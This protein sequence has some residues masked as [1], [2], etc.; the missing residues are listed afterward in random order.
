MKLKPQKTTIVFLVMITVLLVFGN[1]ASAQQI[2]Q[3]EADGPISDGDIVIRGSGFGNNQGRIEILIDIPKHLRKQVTHEPEI[4]EWGSNTIRCNIFKAPI[5]SFAIFTKPVKVKVFGSSG[6]ELDNKFYPFDDVEPQDWFSS[7]VVSIW[8]EGIVGGR[9]TGIFAPDDQTT[10]AEFIK[11]AVLGAG[12]DRFSFS[13]VPAYSDVTSE[14]WFFPYVKVAWNLGWLDRQQSLFE[15]HR[16]ILRAEAAK[17]IS[18]AVGVNAGPYSSPYHDVSEGDWFALFVMQITEKGIVNGYPDGYFRP[19]NELNR[20][21]ASKIIYL[22]FLKH[23]DEL[24]LSCYGGKVIF[25]V[26]GL[27]SNG[28]SWGLEGYDES[29]KQWDIEDDSMLKALT[30]A[31][32]FYGGNLTKHFDIFNDESLYVEE[33]LD[34][35]TVFSVHFSDSDDLTLVEQANELG[36]IINKVVA[37]RYHTDEII[38]IGHSMGG[39]AIRAYIE[40]SS[41][42]AQGPVAFDPV[43]TPENIRNRSLV[44]QVITVNTPHQGSPLPRVAEAYQAGEVDLSAFLFFNDKILFAV[45]I[46]VGFMSGKEAIQLLGDTNTQDLNTEIGRLQET[47]NGA[48]YNRVDS[49]AVA[50]TKDLDQ[51]IT[52][53]TTVILDLYFPGGY[54]AAFETMRDEVYF[55]FFYNRDAEYPELPDCQESDLVV[56]ASSQLA[57]GKNNPPVIEGQAHNGSIHNEAVKSLVRNQVGEAGYFLCPR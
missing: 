17:I 29:L 37:S 6:Q 31:G 41:I 39:L 10:R 15:P 3:I 50:T 25:L 8:R 36:E 13:D 5:F 55:P 23:Q 27:W 12:K 40:F 9:S 42:P 4:L 1:R 28:Y 38:L 14:D 30:D 32:Y 52:G 7:F 53:F 24:K 48:I 44:S 2:T 51:F 22:A 20:A 33:W 34:T 57:F 26:H 54:Q 19:A 11:M 21:E 35:A 18:M 56:C 47:R 45:D 43:L 46:L 16:P 49:V